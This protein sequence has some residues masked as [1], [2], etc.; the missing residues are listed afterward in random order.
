MKRPIATLVTLLTLTFVGL[1]QPGQAVNPSD[2]QKLRTENACPGCDLSGANLA[3]E[4]LQDANL[5]GANLTDANLAGAN[6]QDANLNS[7]VLNHA[8]LRRANLTSAN[9]QYAHLSYAN[10][11]ESTLI[12]TDLTQAYLEATN[13]TG[14]TVQNP[15]LNGT[16]MCQAT[17][18]DGT[19]L[20]ENCNGETSLGHLFIEEESTINSSSGRLW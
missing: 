4:D 13:L 16:Y 2:L 9:C 15:I 8:N 14:A 12:S 18:P 7:A 6:L 17:L 3:G 11:E 20:Y 10:L 5:M 1:S 19:H